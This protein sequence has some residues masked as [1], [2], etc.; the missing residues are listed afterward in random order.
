MNRLCDDEV[1]YCAE[2]VS[3][4]GIGDAGIGELYGTISDQG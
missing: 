4:V 2:S 3:D 1:T